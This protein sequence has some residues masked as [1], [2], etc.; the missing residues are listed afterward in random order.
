M[1]E[2]NKRKKLGCGGVG[3]DRGGGVDTTLE[4]CH[5]TLEGN[6]KNNKFSEG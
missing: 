1:E 4:K 5:Q 6:G 2:P 3:R